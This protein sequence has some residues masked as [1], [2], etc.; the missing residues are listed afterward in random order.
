MKAAEATATE[1][2][3]EESP[4]F[5][6]KW[7]AVHVLSGHEQKVKAY[8]E[9]EIRNQGLGDRFGEILVPAEQITEMREGKKRTRT[10]IFFPGYIL[11][12]M[13]LDKETQHL[14]LNVPGVTNFVGTKDRPVPL[15][16]HEVERI[17]GRVDRTRERGA[18]AVPFRIGDLVRVVDGPFT[19]FT[20]YVEEINEEKNKVKVMVSI[21]GRATP[22]EL[23]F[24]QV[25]LEK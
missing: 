1:G 15:Q 20:G 7:Y 8:L 3:G 6:K 23:D 16:P 4:A 17:L 14:V 2:R 9:N 21:F 24:L 22:V 25:E 5:E 10:R 19:D 18:M 12:E 11:V 13:H